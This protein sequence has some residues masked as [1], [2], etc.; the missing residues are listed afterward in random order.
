MKLHS[1]RTEY[2]FA[3]LTENSI[4]KNPLK[5][6]EHWLTDAISAKVNEPTA[7]SVITV[8]VD[9][10]PDSRMVLLK[11]YNENGF[12]FFTNYSS[13]KGKAIEKNPSVGLHFFWP[14]LERQIRILGFAEKTSAEI[15]DRYFNSR[16]VLSQIAAI[17]SNQSS[18]IPSRDFLQN[19]FENLKNEIAGENLKRPENWGGFVVKPVKFEF[20]QG[21]ESRLHDRILYEN[22]NGSW[23]ISRLAP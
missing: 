23:M 20:W 5:Q 2:K 6:F 18:K 19:Q 22:D 17:V 10:F 13:N 7:M 14:E 16:P 3:E 9:G 4:D 11:D 1:I 8:G 12:T 21:R 15:S